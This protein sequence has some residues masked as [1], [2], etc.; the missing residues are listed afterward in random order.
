MSSG[1][2]EKTRQ[3]KKEKTDDNSAALQALPGTS[4]L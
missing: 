4:C 2:V 3:K 1:P